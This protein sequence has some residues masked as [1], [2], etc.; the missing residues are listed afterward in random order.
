MIKNQLTTT[1]IVMLLV[2]YKIIN[3]ANMSEI[4]GGGSS[5]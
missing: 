1:V 5:S 2:K 3:A 4:L